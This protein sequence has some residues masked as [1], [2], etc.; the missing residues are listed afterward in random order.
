VP[1]ANNLSTMHD[2]DQKQSK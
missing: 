2:S 1:S